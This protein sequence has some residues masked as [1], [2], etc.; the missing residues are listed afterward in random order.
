MGREG[1][2]AVVL[3]TAAL[4]GCVGDDG[5]ATVPT[6]RG[7][8]PISEDGSATGTG[9]G[10]SSTSEETDAPGTGTDPSTDEGPSPCERVRENVTA[11]IRS[12]SEDPFA[13]RPTRNATLRTCGDEGVFL[14]AAYGLQ[15]TDVV[16]LA[17]DVA[18]EARCSG[19]LGKA[20][21]G[22]S[23]RY[24]VA[25]WERPDGVPTVGGG[26]GGGGSP[27]VSA[28]PVST[29]E[30]TAGSGGW[31]AW[32]GGFENRS[33]AE[34]V[35]RYTIANKAWSPVDSSL[36]DGAAFL[37]MLACEAPIEFLGFGTSSV[38]H[39]FSYRDQ[40]AGASAWEHAAAGV[41]ASASTGRGLDVDLSTP[42]VLRA[43][44]F[45]FDGA[46]VLRVSDGN[47]TEEQIIS[48]TDGLSVHRDVPEGSLTVDFAQTG[49]LAVVSGAAHGSFEPMSEEDVVG[50]G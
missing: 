27:V 23:H 28:G 40:E 15:G 35:H 24:Y 42:V 49:R 33:L 41:W 16:S 9:D 2:V 3:F 46:G 38:L 19:Y 21:A 5:D 48:G 12:H 36:T 22:G 39:M 8:D 44:A 11:S 18:N 30:I 14:L 4:A 6:A 7:D 47:G 25:G 50:T 13:D 43:S 26:S 1:W 37:V 10:A 20:A 17:W 29:D 34:G 31:T 32:G 45:V